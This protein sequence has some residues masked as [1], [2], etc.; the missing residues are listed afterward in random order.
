MAEFPLALFSVA[1]LALSVAVAYLSFY[2][3]RHY[4]QHVPSGWRY[5]TFALVLLAINRLATLLVN[6]GS[7]PELSGAL[8]LSSQLIFFLAG[9][10]GLFGFWK[11]RRTFEEYERVDKETMVHIRNFESKQM[12]KQGK[13]GRR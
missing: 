9:L 7:L 5:I 4:A 1:S 8:E 10:V 13:K 2:I 3:Y 6:L 11:I 12:K